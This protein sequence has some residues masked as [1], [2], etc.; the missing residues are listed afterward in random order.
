MYRVANQIWH[1]FK[2]FYFVFLSLL[3]SYGKELL[4]AYYSTIPFKQMQKVLAFTN[5]F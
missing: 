2:L 3:R 4:L 5:R 1:V